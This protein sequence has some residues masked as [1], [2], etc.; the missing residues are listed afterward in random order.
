MIFF[1][2]SSL[3]FA[4]MFVEMEELLCTSSQIDSSASNDASCFSQDIFVARDFHGCTI[5]GCTVALSI[6]LAVACCN[7]GFWSSSGACNGVQGGLLWSVYMCLAIL[8]GV[9]WTPLPLHHDF[10]SVSSSAFLSQY[11]QGKQVRKKL[12][13]QVKHVQR[14]S[15]GV[16]W[17]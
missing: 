10:W 17:Y 2:F 15:I 16:G 1:C 3:C 6:C 8:C 13:A 9:Y 7:C 14:Y 4:F 11:L 5:V 12:V